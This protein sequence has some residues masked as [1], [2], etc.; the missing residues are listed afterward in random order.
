MFGKII[1]ILKENFYSPHLLTII[2]SSYLL[3]TIV[4]LFDKTL[5]MG[6]IFIVFLTSVVFSIFKKIGFKTKTIYTLFLIAL[7]IHLGT[8]FFIH[9]IGFQPF[10]GSAGDYSEYDVIAR[11][12]S[13]RIRQGNFS[14]QGLDVGHN[15]PVILGYIYILTLPQA[16]IGQMFNA[17]LIALLVVFVYLI[18]M[19]IGGLK[20]EAFLAGLIVSIYPSLLFF[21]SLLLK[22]ALVALSFSIVLLL[23]LKLLKAFSWPKFII[24]Y[25]ALSALF[26]F[27]LYIACAAVLTFIACWFLFS[28]LKIKKRLIYGVIIIALLG[29]LPNI[30]GGTSNGAGYFGINFMKAFLNQKMITY[31]REF[32]AVANPEIPPAVES[33][34][35]VEPS[36][37]AKPSVAT[38]PPATVKPSA[39]VESSVTVKPTATAEPKP[40][41]FTDN[42]ITKRGRGSN[43]IVKT[44]FGNP[45]IFLKNSLISFIYAS[46]GPFPWQMRYLRH[47]LIL[48]ETILLY[49]SIFFI[50]K[51]IK[52]PIKSLA[53]TLLFFSI[54]LLAVLSVFIA[55]FGITTRIRVPAFISLFALAPFGINWTSNNKITKFLSKRLDILIKS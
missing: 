21:G 31:Y 22:D 47:F 46:L 29:F 11:Q 45:F 42:P 35:T 1:S 3:L 49:F 20:K 26:H 33:P 9:Y 10:S 13:E 50:I 19:E 27:R 7:L 12:I 41:G 38:K 53:F 44:G 43:V 34:V 28:N 39:T 40:S 30:S 32:L 51:G 6:I 5:A 18:V 14:V 24:F 37:A 4:S 2:I 52:K 15:Y 16:L 25:V 55:N 23:I 54:L 48:P 36:A 8:V 17:W